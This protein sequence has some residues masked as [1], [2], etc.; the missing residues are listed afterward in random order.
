MSGIALNGTKEDDLTSTTGRGTY[1]R[2]RDA[3]RQS[4]DRLRSLDATISACLLWVKGLQF[5]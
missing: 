3:D 2:H 5:E 1:G 4:T